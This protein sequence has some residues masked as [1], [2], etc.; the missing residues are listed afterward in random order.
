MKHTMIRLTAA[1]AL[2]FATSCNYSNAHDT[3]ELPPTFRVVSAPSG[4]TLMI[5]R[6]NM[7][8]ET[9]CE[10]PHTVYPSDTVVIAM[11]GYVAFRGQIEDLPQVARGTYSC[12]LGRK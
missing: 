4:A 12:E 5:E 2:L 3:Q 10:L 7:K 9:P 1:A 6:L 8:L 11:D